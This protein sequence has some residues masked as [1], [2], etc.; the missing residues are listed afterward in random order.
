MPEPLPFWA[1]CPDKTRHFETLECILV[2]EW[3][4]FQ[5]AF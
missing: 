1:N 5:A 4:Q 3:L 2:L